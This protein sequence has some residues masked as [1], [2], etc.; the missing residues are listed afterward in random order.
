MYWLHTDVHVLLLITIK[1]INFEVFLCS[2]CIQF[3]M[4]NR[5][6][7]VNVRSLVVVDVSID[8]E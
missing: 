8:S 6:K 2:F 7:L 5:L 3:N 4:F 1:S